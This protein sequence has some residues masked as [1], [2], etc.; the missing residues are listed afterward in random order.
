MFL[1]KN[2]DRIY[3]ASD[4]YGLVDDCDRVYNLDDDCFGI[5]EL[6]SKELGIEVNGI[7]SSFEK[8]IKDED[9]SKV[10]ITSRDVS[11]KSFKHYL[12]K[13]I[14]ETKDIVESTILRYIK[15]D[16]NKEHY[17]LKGDLLR[18]D[19]ELLTK[20]KAN[21][22]DEIVITGMGTCHT[23]AVSIA[24]NMRNHP[25]IKQLQIRIVAH[26]ASELSA[27]H[28]RED[29]SNTL[30]I[31]IAQSGTTI[32]TNVSDNHTQF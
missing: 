20:F 3:F 2:N 7:S 30:V 9:Y 31:A 5:I 25:I 28:L 13:E 1:G 17:F 11:K 16:F 10:I 24:A 18:I 6:D 19:K 32:D 8:R 14:Y 29:M 26:L 4:A 15:P 27:F 22:I 23:A 21:E 12:L